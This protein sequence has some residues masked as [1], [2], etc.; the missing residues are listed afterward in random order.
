MP[1][2]RTSTSLMLVSAATVVLSTL[3]FA[4][5]WRKINK[6]PKIDRYDVDN[7]FTN[8]ATVGNLV[9]M[10][11]QVGS[12]ESIEEQTISAL[13]E[14]TLALNKA[15]SDK[16]RILEITIWL[17]DIG[18]DYHAMNMIY[19]KWIV[20]DKPPCRACVQAELYSPSCLVEVRA[21]ALKK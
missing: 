9:F 1:R 11:G 14:L 10:S 21:I 8:V 16:S 18:R 17:K 15:G 19:D 4:I 7:R 3:Y 5:L 12:G 2:I 20:K 6:S 13:E